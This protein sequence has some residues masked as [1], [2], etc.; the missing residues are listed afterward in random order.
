M[1]NDADNSNSPMISESLPAVDYA[2]GYD[3][4]SRY[5]DM[6]IEDRPSVYSVRNF[7]VY[8]AKPE[9]KVTDRESMM[10]KLKSEIAHLENWLASHSKT[11]P[12]AS[13]SLANTIR[14]LIA[15]RKS[16][17][18]SLQNKFNGR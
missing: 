14:S 16:L 3:A 18:E 5:D 9:S 6:V 10:D 15:T 4:S 2:A 13:L 7:D 8:D 11:R 17:L 12:S 1:A